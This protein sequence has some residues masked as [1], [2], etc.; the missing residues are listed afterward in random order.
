[1]TKI[2]TSPIRWSGSKRKI[3]KHILPLIDD[4]KDC[5]VE[6]FLG[7]GTMLINILSKNNYKK[8]YVNDINS[9]LINFFTQLKEFPISLVEQISDISENYNS[10][11]EMERKK[12][13]FYSIRTYYNSEQMNKITRAALFWFLTKTCFNGVYRINNSGKYNVPFGRKENAN[14]DPELFFRISNMI[15]NVSFYNVD[16]LEF[17]RILNYEKLLKN[18]FIYL[19]PP[20]VPE[21]SQ[22]Q[23]QKIYTSKF[24]EHERFI[25]FIDVICNNPDLSLMISMSDSHYSQ[26]LYDNLTLNKRKVVDIIRVVNPNALLSSAEIIY[27]NYTKE[28]SL[29]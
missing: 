2:I 10:F 9:D 3:I 20:Y 1:M 28:I 13:Y 27:T 12:D 8:Y 23:R 25:D 21:T 19:D 15:S 5:Y 14:F 26:L 16:Y 18:S 17:L 22:T 11:S 7:S 6:P 29:M 24:F 4:N